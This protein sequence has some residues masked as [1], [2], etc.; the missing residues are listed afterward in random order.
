MIGKA[1]IIELAGG[2]AIRSGKA[3]LTGPCRECVEHR[4]LDVRI[5]ERLRRDHCG[6]L[7]GVH[8]RFGHAW[9][10]SSARPRTAESPG[11]GRVLAASVATARW[12]RPVDGQDR[13]DGA[14]RRLLRTESCRSSP[15]KIRRITIRCRPHNQR[16]G[17]RRGETREAS[18]R[19]PADQRL[20]EGRCGGA[21]GVG[22]RASVC[23][24]RTGRPEPTPSC[25]T[26]HSRKRRSCV[27]MMEAAASFSDL[28]RTGRCARSCRIR[29]A[30]STATRV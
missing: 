3:S 4:L 7:G 9:A 16:S 8:A 22:R 18:A 5:L 27:I 17:I 6:G 1:A 21:R 28:L 26:A 20:P 12:H 14:N 24:R 30:R 19:R 25:R 23:S 11:C 2:L 13:P 29:M 15:G 10:P